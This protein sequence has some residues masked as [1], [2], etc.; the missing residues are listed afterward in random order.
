MQYVE[1]RGSHMKIFLSQ[2]LN[3]SLLLTLRHTLSPHKYLMIE[4]TTALI[5]I[6]GM[7]T[8]L[9]KKITLMTE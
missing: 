9:T 3:L 2:F 5:K 1:L 8:S 4:K 7:G 6:F